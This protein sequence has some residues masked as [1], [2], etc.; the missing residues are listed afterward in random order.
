L[1]D[2]Q[3][4]RAD[5]R[6]DPRAEAAPTRCFLGSLSA[7]RRDALADDVKLL[8]GWTFD[9]FAAGATLD[10][11]RIVDRSSGFSSVP[12][13]AA[14]TP[15][16]DLAGRY[17]LV[18]PAF[19]RGRGYYGLLFEALGEDGKPVA[20]ILAN[21]LFRAPVA[22][23]QPDGLATDILTNAA[24]AF[25][26]STDG[27]SDA[28]DAAETA[29]GAATARHVALILA[30][31]SQAGATAQLQAAVL[32]KTHGSNP[33]PSGFLTLNAA[34][35]LLSVRGLGLDPAGIDGVNISK[36]EDP[37][38][39]PHSLLSNAVGRQAYIHPDG[40]AGLTPGAGTIF[41]ALLH[42][43]EHLLASFDA[44]KLGPALE[45]A[46]GQCAPPVPPEPAVTSPDNSPAR[47]DR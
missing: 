22:L 39:G 28:L 36:D 37:T 33:V 15:L 16:G 13:F 43:Q 41:E 20:L 25:D 21:R 9:A 4:S 30:G 7:P 40:T 24:L 17:R 10:A 11:G 38:F 46:L 8:I 1:A 6:A 12:G 35:S 14:P 32:Q 42:P 3:P 2:P 5:P 44:V 18:R 27:K 23:E 31:Q 47:F 34:E 45:L 29:Y 26:F 19:D